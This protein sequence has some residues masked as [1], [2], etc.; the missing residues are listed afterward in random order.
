M[1]ARPTN[2]P[3][4]YGFDDDLQPVEGDILDRLL[5]RDAVNH[6]DRVHS[7][8]AA[9]P[10]SSSSTQA[11]PSTPRRSE[12]TSRVATRLELQTPDHRRLSSHRDKHPRLSEQ[13]LT[14]DDYL[15]AGASPF[16][17][18]WDPSSD[19]EALLGDDQLNVTTRTNFGSLSN[20]NDIVF[21]PLSESPRRNVQIGRRLFDLTNSS[22]GSPLSPL[23]SANLR[24]SF[25]LSPGSDQTPPIRRLERIEETSESG[26]PP[27][28]LASP[29]PS[30]ED[31]AT[32]VRALFYPDSA[33]E[34]HFLGTLFR[35]IV[36]TPRPLAIQHVGPSSPPDSPPTPDCPPPSTSPEPEPETV[37]IEYQ[38]QPDLFIHV[39]KYV[40]EYYNYERLVH[41]LGPGQ[42]VP[43]TPPRQVNQPSRFEELDNDDEILQNHSNSSVDSADSAS[44]DLH[45][46]DVQAIEPRVAPTSPTM[47]TTDEEIRLMRIRINRA[48]DAEEEEYSRYDI[49]RL[50]KSFLRRTSQEAIQHKNDLAEAIAVLKE[51]P[52]QGAII[53]KAQ[54][55]KTGIVEFIVAAQDALYDHSDHDESAS[56]PASRQ[57]G[58]KTKL[59]FKKKR[60]IDNEVKTL[61]DIETVIGELES[62]TL[63]SP[64]SDQ[65]YRVVADRL[66]T[67]TKRSETVVK[68]CTSLTNDA[69]DA[70]LPAQ[71]EALENNVR[72]LKDAHVE[73]EQKINDLKISMGVFGDTNAKLSELKP[74]TFSGDHETGNDYFTFKKE[75]WEYSATKSATH[76]QQLRILLKNCLTGPAASL[77]Q[78]MTSVD[79]V[80]KS[81]QSHY[82]CAPVLLNSR[83]ADFKSLGTCPSGSAAKKRTWLITA[84][85]KL[86]S[87]KKLAHDHGLENNLYFSNILSEVRSL[88]PWKLEEKFKERLEDTNTDCTDNEEI[89]TVL[90]E[91]FDFLVERS[92]FDVK[93]EIA[94]GPRQSKGE[95]K[96][97]TKRQEKPPERQTLRKKSYAVV[98]ISDSSDESE[99]DCNSSKSRNHATS[100]V[101]NKKKIHATSRPDKG[102]GHVTARSAS[103]KEPVDTTCP[104]CK[105]KHKYLFQ[106]EKFQQT[107]VKDRVRLT[108]ATK[109]C[110]RC[111]RL[112][113]Q[114]NMADKDKWW[115]SHKDSCDG[116]W[117]CVEEDCQKNRANR[118]WHITMC[119]RHTRA[120]RDR[121][122]DF[123][124]VHKNLLK[125]AATMFFLR[126]MVYN[127]DPVPV[128]TRP[129]HAAGVTVHE[130]VY[131]PSIF[132]LQ[133][134][135]APNNESLL[136]FYD[137][138]CSGSALNDR[139]CEVLPKR[140]ITP[141]PT[142]VG[143]AG[144]QTVEVP[145][146][147]VQFWLELTQPHEQATLTGLNMPKVTTPFPFWDLQVAFNDLQKGYN[148]TLPGGPALPACPA[149]LGGTEVDVM[150]GIRYL[151]YFPEKK[152]SLPCGLSIFEGKFKAP[153][154]LVGI[155]GG[156]HKSWRNANDTAQLLTRS[157][158]FTNELT[159]YRVTVNTLRHVYREVHHQDEDY[160][161]KDLNTYC[162][163]LEE[164]SSAEDSE[165][166][167][168]L[169]DEI[170]SKFNK[171]NLGN[172]SFSLS[173]LDEEE[174]TPV[175]PV[176]LGESIFAAYQPPKSLLAE[177]DLDL[178]C[179]FE[180]CNSHKGEKWILPEH[181]DLAPSFLTA[182]Q[183]LERF[184]NLDSL[185]SEI[186]YRCLRCRNC[187][188][189]R[190]GD[191][192]EQGSLEGEVQQAL[193]ERCI[194]LNIK[195]KRLE[196]SL[197]F[198]MDPEKN[199]APNKHRAMMMLKSQ[200]GKVK[201]NPAIREDVLKAHNKLLDKGHVCAIRDLPPEE[202]A[203]VEDPA[204]QKNHIPWNVVTKPGNMS[205]P[206]R[207]T[208]NGSSKTSTGHSLNSILAKGE[209]K[210]PKI[211]HILIKFGSKKHGFT[212]DVSMA[213][214]S[215][216]LYP[217]FFNFQRYLWC[218]SLDIDGEIIEFV[219]KTIIYGIISSGNL[220]AA[221]F[222]LLAAYLRE[223]FPHL[224]KGAEA[225]ENTYVDDTAHAEDTAEE[226]RSVA[227][228]MDYA[229]SLASM[230]V[231]AHTFSGEDPSEVVSA[232]GES[233]GLLGYIWW[234]KEDVISINVKELFFGKVDRG[235]LPPPVS[236]DLAT[237]L[238]KTFTRRTLVAKVAS[239][240][241]PLGYA[242]PITSRIKLDL[243]QITEL[244]TS[245]DQKLPEPFIGQWVANL[246]DLQKLRSLRVQRCWIDPN[247]VS[248]EVELVISVDASEKIAIAC[249]HA[250]SQLPD[251]TF[252]CRLV[253]AKSKLVHMTT[254]PRGELKAAVLGASMAHIIKKNLGSRVKKTL[255]VTDSTIVMF[256][257]NQDTRPLQTTVR[258]S[259]IEIRR[260]SHVEQ[261]FHIDSKNNLADLGT[262]DAQVSDITL[263]SE[264]QSGK[265]W[266]SLPI[267]QMPIRS[268][269]EVQLNQQERQDANKEVKAADICGVCLPALKDK[270]AERYSFSKYVVDP[271]LFPWPKSVRVLAFVFKFIEKL[272]IAVKLKKEQTAPEPSEPDGEPLEV[273]NP[274]SEG[275]D[276]PGKKV[277]RSPPTRSSSPPRPPRTRARARKEAEADLNILYKPRSFKGYGDTSIQEEVQDD[278]TMVQLRN[279]NRISLFMDDQGKLLLPNGYVSVPVPVIDE[280]RGLNPP[281]PDYVS[282][283]L[284]CSPPEPPPL[285]ERL[286]VGLQ[287]HYPLNSPPPPPP[288]AV[289]S[290][291]RP[292]APSF[293]PSTPS[294]IFFPYLSSGNKEKIRDFQ[295]SPEEINIAETYFFK[296]ATNEVKQFVKAVEY[297]K[298]TILKDGILWYNGRILEGQNVSDPEQIMSDLEPLSFVKPVSDRYSP[299][300][301]AI[302]LHSHAKLTHHRN[303][304]ST[305]R[306]SRNLAFIF[307]GRDLSNEVREHCTFCKRFRA[308]LIEVEMGKMHQSRLTCAPAFY[309]AQVDLFGKYQ[310]YCEHNHRAVVPVW[311]VIFKDP[312]SGAIAI[313][314]MAKYSTGAFI[315]AYT[316]HS[317]RYGHPLKLFIDAGSQLMKAC[318]DLEFSWT[319]LTT[320]L[321]SQFGVGIVHAVCTTGS[322]AAHG[323]VERSVLEVKRLLNVTYRLVTLDLYGYDTAFT[324]I[325]NEL[326]SLPLCLGSRY[327]NLEHS[328]LITPSRLLLGRNNQRAPAGYPRISSKSRQIDQLDQVHKAW[329]ETWKKEKLVDYIPA[330]SKWHKNSRPPIVGDIV[331]FIRDE[332]VLGESLWKLG[333][334]EKLI[335]SQADGKVRAVLI[336]YRNPTELKN[337]VTKRDVRKMAI[338]YREGELELMEILNEASKA[339]DIRCRVQLQ[340]HTVHSLLLEKFLDALQLQSSEGSDPGTGDI[341][342]L[343]HSD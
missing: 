210:L 123:L 155:L 250:R 329:W 235:R 243:S 215:V 173:S 216:K 248:N 255:F 70:E 10:P 153:D 53:K 264:W 90:T 20:I 100:K 7:A 91:F 97:D 46:P 321:N 27:D 177:H 221:G 286:G 343:H 125:P 327:E 288:P 112:D 266:M 22:P 107:R 83:I 113:S 5:S 317:S 30:T 188:D 2:E 99:K 203:I 23:V 293:D 139:A 18:E 268:R 283:C 122:K 251:G 276:R 136:L 314:G 299:V 249:V 296:K 93:Y 116:E 14:R 197:P 318:K 307:K 247:A 78:E 309:N 75:Y 179:P 236:G 184:E 109:A 289:A 110:F 183:D 199:L 135:V 303:S 151:K 281:P 193:I 129:E 337:R 291:L 51:C 213:Y 57:E 26:S 105:N 312:S 300:S 328:D 277:R 178:K 55:A 159:A 246:E 292:D 279:V 238:S 117:A 148:D 154:N 195:E 223:H 220:T 158:F 114:V 82:G 263:G 47:S 342:H 290:R 81:L 208:F 60:V 226:L 37:V 253:A 141:G 201:R 240:F 311:G 32:V 228:A 304:I 59:A 265:W 142:K 124:K 306:E 42:I 96:K 175:L 127:L 214:N 259:V 152:F 24:F 41:L 77:C 340:H 8:P 120:N 285:E 196:T 138:G 92:S 68:E 278:S 79:Q 207:M 28:P 40:V 254:V 242:T 224:A 202:K 256:W 73:A 252:A 284:E 130:D 29:P 102:K 218:P 230:A 69:L 150:L 4:F 190:K 182:R 186:T 168:E 38:P 95:E 234:S 66:A 192:L 334:I 133:K 217:A 301:Y 198:I 185:G 9:L 260:L 39:S 231:K 163:P 88:L 180:H 13:W 89:F 204:A 239:I 174:S 332:A 237:A 61:A 132:M 336:S 143:V 56:G 3:P 128:Q 297:K 121:E 270:V 170:F 169:E 160:E 58:N 324:Y 49:L 103:Y 126:P 275:Y 74:P 48:V 161:I 50:P 233:V 25:D 274:P 269:E 147:D 219:I 323:V 271:C 176:R 320:T 244:K 67:L 33:P 63:A 19:I 319:D 101:R 282:D 131:E 187:N 98:Q 211:F 140:Q 86:V 310:A 172:S 308:R 156:T 341:V 11:W 316:R 36:S 65:A 205:T 17:G 302:M 115:D 80:M 212:S 34:N 1:P 6:L 12:R 106:C 191:L 262:R 72:K 335:P 232:D 166:D 194:K 43:R 76:A 108:K 287:P 206:A 119:V 104:I 64:A 225:L 298:Q 165:A 261:W 118:Q 305:L 164:V 245:W 280:S 229:L 146:G 338:L 157:I 71:A 330:P 44:S 339:D 326:N 134:V 294:K 200:L 87:I 21:S 84:N 145:G 111:L 62:L 144:G 272:K 35:R 267:E 15:S 325:A 322:H 333:V 167:D 273:A 149:D 241:D 54:K 209:N 52:D 257:L 315:N 162:P 313:Y 45:R 227:A 16:V 295:L 137:S 171:K 189:C 331:V 222:A 85:Q 258:N 94:L 31:I 181:W